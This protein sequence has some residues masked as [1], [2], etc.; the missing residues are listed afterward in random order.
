RRIGL[1]GLQL[2][3]VVFALELIE[4]A[5]IGIHLGRGLR[6]RDAL[7]GHEQRVL[8]LAA[9]GVLQIANRVA[10]Q[11]PLRQG[12]LAE[13]RIG[14]QLFELRRQ[15]RDVGIGLARGVRGRRCKTQRER[16]HGE[17]GEECA[18]HGF[19]PESGLPEVLADGGISVLPEEAGTPGWS[20]WMDGSVTGPRL[21]A[22]TAEEL[23]GAGAE[24][25][26]GAGGAIAACC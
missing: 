20:S 11:G 13:H 14:I 7:F 23:P 16:S 3:L 22:G 25:P 2:D 26:A 8:A 9:A 21:D 15:T 24:V 1:A 18:L 5:A 10:R 19:T 17:S 6:Q 4:F 12:V